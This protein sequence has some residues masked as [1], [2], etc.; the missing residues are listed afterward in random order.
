V[1]G[2]LRIEAYLDRLYGYAISL[3][4]DTEQAR[5]LVQE[6]AV[7]ALGARQI[8]VDRAAYRAWLFRILRNTFIDGFRRSRSIK[9]EEIDETVSDASDGMP[10]VDERLINV[11][12]VR[13]AFARLSESHREVVALIDIGGLSY[14]EAAEVL[15]IAEG[16]V[17][18]RLCRA[19]RALLELVADAGPSVVPSQSRRVAR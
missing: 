9:L 14:A 15:G 19:R 18:S 8:P 2:D 5:D 12:T 13:S 6:C 10:L 17:M 7:R 11:M 4:Q 16:T 1:A 3:T